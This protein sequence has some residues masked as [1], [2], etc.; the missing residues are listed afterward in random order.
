MPSP[1]VGGPQSVLQV[2]N[3]EY[4]VSVGRG[5]LSVM[6]VPWAASKFKAT[7]YHPLILSAT[8]VWLA[9]SLQYQEYKLFLIYAN[10]CPPEFAKL[11]TRPYNRI[12]NKPCIEWQLSSPFPAPAVSS[13]FC[14]ARAVLSI[15]GTAGSTELTWKRHGHS[16]SRKFPKNNYDPR[17]SF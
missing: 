7:S 4:V 12:T 3:M 16:N 13:L 2:S 14:C 1:N 11:P 5:P 8:H 17:Y 15:M 6:K 10:P 9:G